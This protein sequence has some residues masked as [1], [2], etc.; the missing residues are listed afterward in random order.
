MIPNGQRYFYIQS[1]FVFKLIW[2]RH[3]LSV[4][5]YFSTHGPNYVSKFRSWWY[6]IG[7]GISKPDLFGFCAIL[8]CAKLSEI[9]FFTVQSYRKLQRMNCA[10]F[11]GNTPRTLIKSVIQNLETPSCHSTVVT[12]DLLVLGLEILYRGGGWV[13]SR[14]YLIYPYRKRINNYTLKNR[15]IF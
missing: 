9:A 10:I 15:V 8:Y 4:S 2:G 7:S 14:G 12:S 3:L 6:S 11:K 5:V 1:N 13:K